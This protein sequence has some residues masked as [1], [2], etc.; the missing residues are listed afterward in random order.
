VLTRF[1][2]HEV[3]RFA[4]R[5]GVV[6]KPGEEVVGVDRPS[7]LKSGA[8]ESGGLSGNGRFSAPDSGYSVDNLSPAT[9]AQFTG[10]VAPGSLHLNWHANTEADLAGYRL[11]RGFTAD[12]VPSPTTLISSQ[13]DVGYVDVT[14]NSYFYK[15]SAV[16]VHGNK[17]AF[18][19]LAAGVTGVGDASRPTAL[20][21][22]SPEPNPADT[23]T[24]IDFELPRDSDVSLAVYDAGGRMVRTLFRGTHE[25]GR[26][27]TRWNLRRLR[28]GRAERDLLRATRSRRPHAH[29]TDG[30]DP[31]GRQ[32]LRRKPRQRRRMMRV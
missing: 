25:A 6:V 15:L 30:R 28:S 21:L 4:H 14:F 23:F 26:T 12:F 32:R 8:G 2:R 3:E 10:V 24:R 17:S 13:A 31:V 16:D 29:A 9:P 27:G 7:D 19:L 22:A 5:A 1:A 18:A 20:H 11:Y